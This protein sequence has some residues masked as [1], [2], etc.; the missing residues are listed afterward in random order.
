[1][2]SNFFGDTEI[3]ERFKFECQYKRKGETMRTYVKLLFNSEG[4]PPLEVVKDMRSLGFRPEVG[5]F[6]FSIGWKLPSEYGE[7]V[8][9]LHKM[10]HGSKVLYSLVTREED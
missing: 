1:S 7:I 4:K 2:F 10:L 9:N 6:D 5:E 8:T 3:T